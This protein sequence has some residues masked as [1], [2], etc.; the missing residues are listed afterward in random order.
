MFSLYPIF[1]IKTSLNICFLYR[2]F[3]IEEPHFV[4]EEPTFCYRRTAFCY[5]RTDI[6]LSKNRHFV[7]HKPRKPLAL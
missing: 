4:I 2:H 3:V 7:I 6:L 5:R 1:V